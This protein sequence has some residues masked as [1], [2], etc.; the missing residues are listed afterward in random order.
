MNATFRSHWGRTFAV[1]TLTAALL[2]GGT[3]GGTAVAATRIP[4]SGRTRGDTFDN[5]AGDVED[6]DHRAGADDDR[7]PSPTTTTKHSRRRPPSIRRNHHRRR[8]TNRS[9]LHQSPQVLAEADSTKTHKPKP[10]PSKTN[11]YSPKPK[12]SKTHKYSPKPTKTAHPTM[13]AKPTKTS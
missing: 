9:R 11:K 1:G 6:D 13:T 12:P 4:A 3:A 2:S 7:R 5:G 8:P 10:T